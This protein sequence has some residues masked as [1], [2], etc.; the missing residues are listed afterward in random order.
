MHKNSCKHRHFLVAPIALFLTALVAAELAVQQSAPLQAFLTIA[1]SSPAISV[2]TGLQLVPES[3]GRIATTTEI[4]ELL[5]GSTYVMSEGISHMDV[6]SMR[7]MS[8]HGTYFVSHYDGVVSIAAI[9]SP[10]LV[11]QG[12][13]R[14]LIPVR[15]QWRFSKQYLKS[16]S[17]STEEWLADR[18][19][20][21]IPAVFM[22]TAH[23]NMAKHESQVLASLPPALSEVSLFHAPS[24]LLLPSAKEARRIALQK[25]TLGVLRFYLETNNLQGMQKLLADSD[26][27][28]KLSTQHGLQMSSVMLTQAGETSVTALALS[29]FLTQDPD[30]WLLMSVHPQYRALAWIGQIPALTRERQMLTWLRLPESNILERAHGPLIMRRWKYTVSRP[31]SLMAAPH[32]LFGVLLSEWNNVVGQLDRQGYPERMLRLRN[33]TVSLAEPY[34][35]LLS[36]VEQNSIHQL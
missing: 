3:D 15:Y 35:T 29:E 20:E 6:G 5:Y 26:A 27:I 31:L 13:Q 32:K 34:R 21:R 25:D 12:N 8:F 22:E 9:S 2:Q 7:L 14:V 23:R 28:E 10:V 1:N 30:T 16:I 11:Q 24:F 18:T 33:A 36:D 4:P 17:S 19:I